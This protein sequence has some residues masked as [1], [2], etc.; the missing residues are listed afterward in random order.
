MHI[1][2]CAKRAQRCTIAYN[3]QPNNVYSIIIITKKNIPIFFTATPNAGSSNAATTAV[4]A[5]RTGSGKFSNENDSE[6]SS[7]TS[8]S[9]PGG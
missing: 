3:N 2:I 5:T 8:E 6:C 9:M 7:V 4:T 1:V